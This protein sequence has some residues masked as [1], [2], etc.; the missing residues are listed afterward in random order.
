MRPASRCAAATALF[1]TLQDDKNLQTHRN[2]KAIALLI[3]HLRQQG[4]LSDET[5]DEILL[6]CIGGA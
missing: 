5:V 1:Y 3:H 4:T 6:E 2:S